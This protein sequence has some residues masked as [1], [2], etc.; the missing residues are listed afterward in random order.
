MFLF[1]CIVVYNYALGLSTERSIIFMGLTVV[2]KEGAKYFRNLI[3]LLGCRSGIF[4]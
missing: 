2:P 1:T 3:Q 4:C